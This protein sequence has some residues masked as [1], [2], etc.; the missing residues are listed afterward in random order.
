MD[1]ITYRPQGVCA[2]VIQISLDGDKI[3]KVI[4]IGGCQGNAGGISALVK[5]LTIQEA[6]EKLEGIQCGNKG[7]SCPDQFAKALKEY[8]EKQGV[9]ND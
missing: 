5:G 9:K 3:D 6:I 4:F 8:L 7:T 2:K 1:K